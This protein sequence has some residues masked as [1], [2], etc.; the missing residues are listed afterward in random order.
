MLMAAVLPSLPRPYLFEIYCTP[1]VARR[2]WLAFVKV[3]VV[4]AAEARSPLSRS[5]MYAMYMQLR[6]LGVQDG[7]IK[8]SIV[9]ISKQNR[10]LIFFR[11]LPHVF[12]DVFFHPFVKTL[13]SSEILFNSKHLELRSESLHF[14]LQFVH[15]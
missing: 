6:M 3:V 5:T 13:E 14:S 2:R 10:V 4:G 7:K 12:E 9:K 1:T 15:I 11:D 8:F